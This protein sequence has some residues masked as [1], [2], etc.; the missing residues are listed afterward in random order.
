MSLSRLLR[1][2]LVIG[3]LASP[4]AA[5]PAISLRIADGHPWTT[6]GPDGQTMEITFFPDGTARMRIGILSRRMNWVPTE[7]G[8]CLAGGPMGDRC[9]TLEATTTGF[10]GRGDDGQMLEFAR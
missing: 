2:G 6:T 7:A 4:L 3:L 9:I 8:L 10:V 1:S 5:D